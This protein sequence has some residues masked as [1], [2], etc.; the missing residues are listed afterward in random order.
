MNIYIYIL[1]NILYTYIHIYIYI[2]I[3]L[4]I[5]IHIS[6]YIYIYIYMYIYI[7]I[8]TRAH[9]GNHFR[10][11]LCARAGGRFHEALI[12]VM[13]LA[14]LKSTA[15]NHSNLPRKSCAKINKFELLSKAFIIKSIVF[16]TRNTKSGM[17]TKNRT[18]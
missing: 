13:Q 8:H 9:P 14:Q 10:E 16:S 3:Y 4:C 17:Q 1:Y 15:F 11:S 2:H 6:V 5:I 18:S 12:L 7:Y